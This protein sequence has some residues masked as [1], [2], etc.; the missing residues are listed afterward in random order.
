MKFCQL[1]KA[2]PVSNLS[3][4]DRIVSYESSSF[5]S[6][7]IASLD[8]IHRRSPTNDCRAQNSRNGKLRYFRTIGSLHVNYKM[9]GGWIM[10]IG[11]CI[12]EFGQHGRC[13]ALSALRW[14]WRGEFYLHLLH[15]TQ[16]FTVMVKLSASA[17]RE[18]LPWTLL[19]STYH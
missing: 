5:F 16:F 3:R 1:I 18:D 19:H 14:S 13:S 12:V 4:S 9:V 11:I 2:I 15:H 8:Q 17:P 6:R 7:S 10:G